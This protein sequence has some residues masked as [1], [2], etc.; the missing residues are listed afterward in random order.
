MTHFVNW[1]Y[2]ENKKYLGQGKAFCII[3]VDYGKTV[4]GSCESCICER[5]PSAVLNTVAVAYN[6]SWN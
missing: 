3:S 1:F 2:L 6:I 4:I 5:A